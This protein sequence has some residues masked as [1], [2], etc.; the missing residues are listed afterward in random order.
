MPQNFVACDRDQELLL[1]P[2]LREWLPAD[3]LAWLVLEAVGELDLIA[4]YVAA[5]CRTRA[6]AARGPEAART[7][8]APPARRTADC[9]VRATSAA[10][11]SPVRR[12][13][14]R[15]MRPSAAR[16]SPR[17]PACTRAERPMARRRARRPGHTAIRLQ[18]PDP[19]ACR[20]SVRRAGPRPQ[21]A[22]GH[23]PTTTATRLTHDER[24]VHPIP[25]AARSRSPAYFSLKV[26]HRARLV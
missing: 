16:S 19:P 5:G 4:F 3:H 26:G 6:G 12:R 8:N 25:I 2:S 17:S 24:S 15:P 20:Q 21:R 9:R 10:R 1:P 22:Q 13:R 11:P 7:A 18:T 23:H 14:R